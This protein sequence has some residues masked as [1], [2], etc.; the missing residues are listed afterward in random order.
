MAAQNLGDNTS[1]IIGRLF[2]QAFDTGAQMQQGAVN[3][4]AGAQQGNQQAALQTGALNQQ[5]AGLGL[6]AA[7]S[8]LNTIMGGTTAANT[9]T[10]TGTAQA[11][12]L[13]GTGNAQGMQQLFQSLGLLPQLQNA[14][15]SQL[16][17]GNQIGLQQLG[18]NQAGIDS[19]IARFFFNQYAP[20][21]QLAQFQNF[22]TGNYGSSVPHP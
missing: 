2:G 13:L 17:V 6:N 4:I 15:L 10:S 9:A 19:D 1:D 3:T 18:Q 14:G 20:Y 11:G 7:N 5:G 22:I 16:G 12:D 8:I 21:A